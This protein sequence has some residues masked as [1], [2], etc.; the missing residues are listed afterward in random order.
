[1]LIELTEKERLSLEIIVTLFILA[2]FYLVACAEIFIRTDELTTWWI[3]S[4]QI[5]FF[6]IGIWWG[7]IEISATLR[8]MQSNILVVSCMCLLPDLFI[9][10]VS[11]FSFPLF[12]GWA[13]LLARQLA[14]RLKTSRLK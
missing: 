14:A 13:M 6:L 7:A 3:P 8:V 12:A 5:F 11:L 10:S 1:M 9:K 4:V 2:I